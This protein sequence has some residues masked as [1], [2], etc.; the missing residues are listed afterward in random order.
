MGYRRTAEP[1]ENRLVLRRPHAPVL[2]LLVSLLA[3]IIAS[4]FIERSAAAQTLFY[5]LY[6]GML[7][8]ASYAVG[9]RSRTFWVS[10]VLGLG[11]IA[12]L[13]TGHAL[14]HPVVET[15]GLLAYAAFGFVVIGALLDRV[16]EAHRVDFDVL[17]T[18][19][20]IYLL[21]G[22]VW[23]I[24]YIA[25]QD[26]APGSFSMDP[27]SPGHGPAQ[28]L[29]FSLV[30]LSTLGYGDIT[31]VGDFARIWSALE[32]ISG[33]LFIAILVA[34]LVSLYRRYDVEDT[35]ETASADQV[36]R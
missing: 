24:S 15:V 2:T 21:L 20:S 33:V 30:T 36:R 27:T 16:L 12:A 26:L 28:L 18:A 35:G 13:W 19:V 32:A 34:R 11:G 22:V 9:T 5:L 25:V 31:P 10:A 7:L 1:T 23:G 6:T 8:V 3:F 17:C 29:Y 4:P 14:A